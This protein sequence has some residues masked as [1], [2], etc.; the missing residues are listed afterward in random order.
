MYDTMLF[1][2]SPGHMRSFQKETYEF[3]AVHSVLQ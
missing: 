1:P 2:D 3:Y